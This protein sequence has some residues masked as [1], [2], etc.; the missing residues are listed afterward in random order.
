MKIAG[1]Q[2]QP[3]RGA[4]QAARG[5]GAV[6]GYPLLLGGHGKFLNFAYPEMHSSA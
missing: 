5:E 2:L 6:G 3:I 4:V 1:G